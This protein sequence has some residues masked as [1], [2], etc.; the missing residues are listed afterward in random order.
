MQ[1]QGYANLHLLSKSGAS[2]E[3][4]TRRLITPFIN[5]WTDSTGHVH[6]A[7]NPN[8]AEAT[9]LVAVENARTARAASLAPQPALAGPIV[10]AFG[11]PPST[12]SAH[13]VPKFFEPGVF[14][15]LL[16]DWETATVPRRTFPKQ[17][18]A[19]AES[20][21]ARLH[22]ELTVSRLYTPAARRSY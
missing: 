1:A 19:G 21:L 12:P 5:G 15:G 22:H 11:L 16:D 10:P 4:V 9:I 17:L 20:T 18:L 2:D 13:A 3:A 7:T 8:I 6:K 14:Q